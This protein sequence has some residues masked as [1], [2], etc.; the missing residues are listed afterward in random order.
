MPN[1]AQQLV[2]SLHAAGVDTMFANPGTTEMCVVEALDS[3]PGVRGVL[4]LHENVATGAADGFAR[5]TGRPAAVLLH[6]GV[7]LSNG[8]ANLHN[9]KRARS[10][11]LV[12][13]GDMATW[14]L[15]ADS[16][17]ES[18]IEALARVVSATIRT[19]SS[20]DVRRDVA[21]ALWSMHDYRHEGAAR[22][23]RL[24]SP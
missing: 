19:T 5:M 13:V 15:G 24:D 18:D 2:A 4:C 21:S 10:P 16:L 6:L 1:G 20:A 14:H 8:I 11:V 3:Q 17:L 22:T 23:M 9:A 7:G 12:L